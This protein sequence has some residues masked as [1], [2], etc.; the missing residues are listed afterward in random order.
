MSSRVPCPLT[1]TIKG[2]RQ[3]LFR[4]L[5]AGIGS[6]SS[7]LDTDHDEEVAVADNH[8]AS[9][10][11]YSRIPDTTDKTHLWDPNPSFTVLGSAIQMPVPVETAG[12]ASVVSDVMEPMEDRMTSWVLGCVV[13]REVRQSLADDSDIPHKCVRDTD[14]MC[15]MRLDY[16]LAFFLFQYHDS[17]LLEFLFLSTVAAAAAALEIFLSYWELRDFFQFL[18]FQ[19]V[20]LC[21]SHSLR[22]QYVLDVAASQELLLHIFQIVRFGVQLEAPEFVDTTYVE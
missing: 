12:I 18:F 16:F 17:F 7:I 11:S 20:L 10:S 1:C 15:N 6:R 5:S 21:Y 22:P 14:R 19:S 13:A 9:R 3:S 8:H 4:Y 2:K